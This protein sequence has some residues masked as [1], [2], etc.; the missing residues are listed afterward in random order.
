MRLQLVE[1]TGA[2]KARPG[3]YKSILPD[4]EI[5]AVCKMNIKLDQDKLKEV[6][7][8]LTPHIRAIVLKMTYGLNTKP[9]KELTVA[10]ARVLDSCITKTP[11]TP[12]IEVKEKKDGD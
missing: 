6:W 3:T 2:N 11:A 5:K 9:Y 1:L 8:D 12:T 4:Y 10:Q 7:K